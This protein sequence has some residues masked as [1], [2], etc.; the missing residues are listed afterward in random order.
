MTEDLRRPLQK[1]A[2]PINYFA[3]VAH[4][5]AELYPMADEHEFESMKE[6]IRKSGIRTDWRVKLFEGK[7]L[8]GR[9]RYKAAKEA[10]HKFTPVDFDQF[11]GTYE[12]AEAYVIDSNRRRHLSPTQ[13]AEIAKKLIAKYPNYHTRRLAQMAGVSHT[14]IATLRR[15]K[16]D[17]EYEAL[18]RAWDKAS[19][20]QQER[21]VTEHRIDLAEMLKP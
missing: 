9:N 12:E 19:F 4:P 21:F 1:T 17:K 16:D 8:D 10:G 13:K 14:T 20:D 2:E 3:L 15:P 5:L 11:S 18:L 6:S 7:I